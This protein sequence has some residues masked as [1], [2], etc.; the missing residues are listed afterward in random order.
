MSLSVSEVLTPLTKPV[1]VNLLWNRNLRISGTRSDLLKRLTSSYKKDVEAVL[2]ELR[3]EDLLNVGRY[4]AEQF[5]LPG[6]TSLRVDD[7]R[8]LL[9][10]H[11]IEKLEPGTTTSD[12]SEQRE[13][14]ANKIKLYLARDESTF[15]LSG[16]EELTLPVLMKQA[17]VAKKVTVLSAYYVCNVLKEMLGRC[18]GEVRIVLNGLGGQRLTRQVNELEDLQSTLEDLVEHCS[19]RLRH[20]SG[21]FHT[22]LYLFEN[23]SGFEAWV[24]SANVTGAA[25]SGH[26]E[27]ILVHISPAPQSLISYA[28]SVWYSSKGLKHVPT[29]G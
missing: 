12:I 1:L 29:R 28:E 14:V 18:R 27:E 2:D 19:I 25:L 4:Y 16:T 26:N 11:F 20:S 22:K 7:I 21:I 23:A 24:G 15:P 8:N 13:S 10:S 17:A 6:L 9:G 3:R 5:D